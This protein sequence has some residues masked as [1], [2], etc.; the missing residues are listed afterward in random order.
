MYKYTK[1]TVAMYLYIHV[2]DV[3]RTSANRQ[4][5]T[6]N[7]MVPFI[8]DDRIEMVQFWLYSQLWCH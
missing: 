4:V 7:A 3:N 5:R 8:P 6:K 2:Y 1:L